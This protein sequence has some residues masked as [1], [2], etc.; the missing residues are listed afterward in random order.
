VYHAKDKP[1]CAPKSARGV[2]V[3]NNLNL[4]R[5][6]TASKQPIH[7]N[8]SSL[9]E[10]GDKNIGTVSSEV[11]HLARSTTINHYFWTTS[12][13]S[14]RDIYKLSLH[15]KFVKYVVRKFRTRVSR[16]R[17]SP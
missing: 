2:Q 1:P 6:Y 13:F 9:T 17:I 7:R 8:F 5:I 14:D 4:R 15:A 12:F 3:A 10:G 16:C 11:G